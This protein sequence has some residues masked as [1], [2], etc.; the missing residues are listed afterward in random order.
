[1]SKPI[2]DLGQIVATPGAL[3]LGIDFSSYLGLHQRGHWGDICQEDW[4]END[5]NVKKGFRI[6]SVYETGKGRIWIITER[7]RSLTSI[8]LPSEY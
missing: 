3:A 2:F 6:L 8:L 7:N 4:Q 1:M 5:L